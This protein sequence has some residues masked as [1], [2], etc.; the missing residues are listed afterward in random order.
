MRSSRSRCSAGYDVTGYTLHCFGGAGGQH[1]C[2]VADALGMTTV[3]IHPLAGVLSAYGMGLADVR[4]L[5]ERQRRGAARTRTLTRGR[6]GDARPA[7]A[8]A[9]VA[10][11]GID[12]T[13]DHARAPRAPALRGHRHRRW[14]SRSAPTRRDARRLRRGCTGSAS[15][16]SA[17]RGRWS[18]RRSRVEAIG[19]PATTPRTTPTGDRRRQRRAAI[20][21]PYALVGER[22]AGTTCRS[23]D[24]DALGAGQRVAGPA[25][26]AEPTATNSGRARLA[27]RDRR[28]GNLI[29]APR[30][31]ARA[32]EAR[33]HRAP[34]R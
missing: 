12:R 7:D 2:L 20:D 15:A 34:I 16:S 30:R 13:R 29:A 1:A 24:R 27:A 21:E 8:L 5:R 33:R 25:I 17:G 9:E 22:R 28:R 32:R 4:A 19:A 26:I 10:A 6:R 11:Q 3:F 14:S 23:I 31:A 18:S